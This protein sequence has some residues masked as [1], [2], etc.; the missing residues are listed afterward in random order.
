MQVRTA[1]ENV[2]ESDTKSEQN[3]TEIRN[4]ELIVQE[5]LEYSL[6]D[7]LN[8]IEKELTDVEIE[9]DI[10]DKEQPSQEPSVPTTIQQEEAKET[11]EK[12]MKDILFEKPLLLIPDEEVD[13]PLFFSSS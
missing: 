10:K 7:R 9:S 3:A 4:V 2:E 5:P 8:A 13:V 6:E 1:R 12:D 11:D